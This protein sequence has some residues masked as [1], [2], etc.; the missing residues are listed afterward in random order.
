MKKF[1][2]AAICASMIFNSG[3]YATPA[4]A[5]ENE[6][7]QKREVTPVERKIIPEGNAYIPKGTKIPLA[8]ASDF[9]SKT[10]YKG[11]PVPLIT[12]ENI[13]L[14]D[15]VVIPAGTKVKAFV[16][17]ARKAGNMGRAGKLE[18]TVESVETL[19]G[20]EIPLQYIKSATG[21][22]D[23]GGSVAVI[24]AVSIIGGFFM[25]GKNINIGAGTQFEVEVSED[26]DLKASLE[27]LQEEMNIRRPH[28]VSITI[29]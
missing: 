25:K 7:I 2:A 6:I 13:I 27:N 28:G 29:R 16:T 23:V 4:F 19:N 20:A 26:A 15:V 1:V 3:I 12:A 14:N 17:V 9:S 18:F 8:F 10:A 5:D 21:E 11:E 22:N 24:A